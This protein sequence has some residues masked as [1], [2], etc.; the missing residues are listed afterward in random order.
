MLLP[1]LCR[2]CR[3]RCAYQCLPGYTASSR[4]LSAVQVAF[5][6]LGGWPVCG[7]VIA[8]LAMVMIARALCRPQPIATRTVAP[9]RRS[10]T[11]RHLMSLNDG[12]APM[13]GAGLGLAQD[14]AALG[15]VCLPMCLSV[16]WR[17]L[18]F[19]V[20]DDVLFVVCVCLMPFVA[21]PLLPRTTQMRRWLTGCKPRKSA[22]AAGR[23]AGSP[24][25]TWGRAR[26]P[27][28]ATCTASTLL[29]T[30]R[31]VGRLWCERTCHRSWR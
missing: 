5:E 12:A 16:R 30:T 11:S 13:S 17:R 10:S 31:S 9:E 15:C 22:A 2:C 7:S 26:S 25:H 8:V 21:P 20:D 3:C 23:C 24:R 4:C 29:G 19:M 6:A 27:L 18:L 14:A 28:T 1:L